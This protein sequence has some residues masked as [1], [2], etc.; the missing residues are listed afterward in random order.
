MREIFT[1]GSRDPVA[2]VRYVRVFPSLENSYRSVRVKFFPQAVS[3]TQARP[4]HPQLRSASP[5]A[6]DIATFTPAAHSV[7][8]SSA[9][10]LSVCSDIAKASM[11]GLAARLVSNCRGDWALLDA[12]S[13]PLD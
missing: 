2:V 7:F 5:F 8:A 12:E 10:T 3:T 4:S 13:L 9:V 6:S 1:F 11:L